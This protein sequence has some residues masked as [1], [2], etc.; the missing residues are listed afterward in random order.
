MARSKGCRAACSSAARSSA[1]G[2][3]RCSQAKLRVHLALQAQRQR[4]V[5]RRRRPLQLVQEP[6]PA[7]RKGQ[8]DHEL[9]PSSCPAQG[10][11]ALVGR[12]PG[13]VSGV[14]GTASVDAVRG[15]HGGHTA[16][17]AP[18]Q[19]ADARRERHAEWSRM[20]KGRNDRPGSP[21]RS[22]RR[23][24]VFPGSGWSVRGRENRTGIRADRVLKPC[25][26]TPGTH[27]KGAQSR[28]ISAGYP[29]D[30]LPYR[31]RPMR[32]SGKGPGRTAARGRSRLHGPAL[33]RSRTECQGDRS[34][35][36]GTES[37]RHAA[38]FSWARLGHG[39]GRTSCGMDTQPPKVHTVR[40]RSGSVDQAIAS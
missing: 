32:E 29:F 26:H 8:R 17:G 2:I 5:V 38:A 14:G 4:H 13:R 23:R 30:E 10:N 24:P 31:M 27:V 21:A 15:R 36:G 39:P 9:F 7:L 40:T 1:S 6:Q 34:G 18:A 11:A 33:R 3:C 22:L 35:C 25:S 19:G 20:K 28:D 12:R 37:A 16:Y